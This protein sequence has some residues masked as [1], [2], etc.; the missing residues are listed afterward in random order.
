MVRA[1]GRRRR[2]N[3]DPLTLLFRALGDATRR[4]LLCRLT[5]GSAPVTELARPF[6]MSLPAVSKHLRIL[7]QAGLIARTVDGRVHRLALTGAP[8][9]KVEVWLDPF[10]SYW[11]ST[12]EALRDELQRPPPRAREHRRGRR[13]RRRRSR[14]SMG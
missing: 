7:E 8:L 12:L 14:P 10:R 6:H 9:E 4:S 1:G 5:V 13:P 3:R 2:G 11:D